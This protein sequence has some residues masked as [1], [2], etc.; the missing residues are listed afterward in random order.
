MKTLR[1][2]EKWS[3]EYNPDENDRPV[4]LLRKGE[5][6]GICDWKNDTVA[7]FYALLD[8]RTA[9]EAGP[10]SP[11]FASARAE[12]MEPAEVFRVPF[13]TEEQ[14]EKLQAAMLA[15]HATA[16]GQI[17][18]NLTDLTRKT[19]KVKPMGWD[20]EKRGSVAQT[21]AGTFMTVH[22][23][24]GWRWFRV[25]GRELAGASKTPARTE[26]EAKADAFLHLSG[27]ILES[28][29]REN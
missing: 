3:V 21:A 12:G 1:I 26:D 10:T 28:I 20:A 22:D 13:L 15:S 16:M 19:P 4:K 6:L 5:E 23:F 27:L 25:M 18:H 29:E 17:L 8:C 14:A 24:D 11:D 7:M 9:Q 2:D